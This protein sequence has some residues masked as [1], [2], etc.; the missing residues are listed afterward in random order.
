V[1]SRSIRKIVEGLTDI[2]SAAFVERYLA[3]FGTLALSI[4]RNLL[5]LPQGA[6]TTAGPAIAATGRLA[7]AVQ[8]GGDRFVWKLASEN[9]HELDDVGIGSPAILT[10]FILLHTQTRVITTLPMDHK[11]DLVGDHVD[12]NLVDQ[13]TKYLLTRFNTGADTVPRTWKVPPECKEPFA[14]LGPKYESRLSIVLRELLLKH[15]HIGQPLVP[16]SF[17]LAGNQSVVGVNLIILTMRA[18]SF[19]PRLLKLFIAASNGHV[20]SKAI[21]CCRWSSAATPS[22]HVA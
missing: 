11:L 15:T 5:V 22:R 7:R 19:E 17:Q 18:S 13:Q 10:A 20:L 3:A 14:I 1:P 9:S 4:S 16:T 8:D 21:P 12:Y 6:D 2:A